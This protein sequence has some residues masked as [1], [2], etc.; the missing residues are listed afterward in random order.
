MVEG[1]FQEVITKLTLSHEPYISESIKVIEVLIKHQF[2]INYKKNLYDKTPLSMLEQ[3]IEIL[4]NKK[5]T[6]DWD[7]KR[8]EI[9]VEIKTLLLS[10]GAVC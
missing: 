3:E 10:H 8:M 1:P 7:K 6:Y 9:F 2:D 4:S 5:H